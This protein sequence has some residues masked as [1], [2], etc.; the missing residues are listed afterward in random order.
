MA[1]TYNTTIDQGADWYINFIYNQPAKITNITA[2]G[3]TVTFTAV[4]GFV[5]GQSVSITGVN[6]SQF[7]LQN[8]VINTATGTYFTVLNGATGLYINGGTAYAP[9]NVT[10]STAALQLRSLPESPNVALSLTSGNGITV[11]TT[12]GLFE[13]HATAN[14]TSNIDEGTYYYDLEITSIGGIVTRLAQ[15][16]IAVIAEVTR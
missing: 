5:A 10:G 4:N 7:N 14:Q 3:T 9:V 8:V 12:N 11:G 16:Q 6:P 2:N 15:G 13:I 1:V